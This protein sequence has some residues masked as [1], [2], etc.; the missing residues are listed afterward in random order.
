M[1]FEDL[2]TPLCDV[3]FV[4]VD[5]ETTGGSA[6]DSITEV[7]A[8][9]V[10]GGE[11]IGEFGTLVRPAGS[12]PPMI[13]VLT[14]I[15]DAMV[16]HAPRIEAVLPAFLEFASG[17]V[18][19]AHNAPFDIGFLSRACASHGLAWPKP[20]VVDTV[21]L[22][23][24]VLPRS[25]VPN[26]KL[27]TLARHFRAP[28][29]PTHRALDDAKATVHVLHGLLERLGTQHVDTL[30]DLLG[31]SR[32]VPQG[33]RR[34]AG[35]ADGL[36]DAPGVYLFKDDRGR[37]LY[38]GTSRSLRT[39]VRSYF[40]A[41]ET[42]SRMRDMVR[43][44]HEVVPIV[45]PT[46]LEARVRELRLI[47]EHQ[48][49]YNARSR[50]PDRSLWLRLT[51]EP[52]P[53]LSIVR[54]PRGA[55]AAIGP[56]P[57]RESAEAAAACLVDAIPLRQ[58]TD[59]VSVSKHTDAC[60]LAELGRCGA[61]CTGAQT[62]EE[63]ALV[64]EQARVAMTQDASLVMSRAFARMT[65][66]SRAGRYEEAAALRD[67]LTAFL[68][69]AAW[70]QRARALAACPQVVAAAPA[71]GPT[72]RWEVVVI[73]HGRL[74]ASATLN[75]DAAMGAGIRA[76]V[77]TAPY[78]EPEAHGLPAS[79]AEETSAVL[80][81]LEAP[82]VRPAMVEGQWCS[83]LRGA[84]SV[85]TQASRASLDRLA[86]L[87]APQAGSHSG[88]YAAD[89]SE[90]S[91]ASKSGSDPVLEDLGGRAVVEGLL[92]PR[93]SLDKGVIERHAG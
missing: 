90:W 42:R 9:K 87:N 50:R 56:F 27:A 31:Y 1:R 22:A 60:I 33:V 78:A 40:T 41:A 82:G 83:P 52:F 39:R 8:V 28:V 64:V 58:C 71:P 16:A 55:D 3:T 37:V 62:R 51:D 74:V 11:V 77:A 15:T 17:S 13:S 73:R 54:S 6:D 81:W 19:V 45:C 36:P 49:P 47:A 48:P 12:I 18:L 23:R 85:A 61:P 67:R 59:R 24:S 2:G 63:Y 14:G 72:G 29:Q 93:H 7:G 53:R 57:R 79:T 70:S 26:A 21:R 10:R 69:G 80:A 86:P 20:P 75:A 4:V 65:A 92:D 68:G 30:E 32:Q 5:L 89:A 66:R 34:K 88:H 84:A 25:E 91:D 44:A 76:L 46:P 43:L 35:L 38:V